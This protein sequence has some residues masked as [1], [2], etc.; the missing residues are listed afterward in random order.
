MEPIFFTEP[1]EFRVWLEQHHD[2]TKELWVGYYKK[3]TGKPSMTWP[4]S[5]DE[6]LCFGWIDG[7]RKGIDDISYKIRFT[8]RKARSIW[9][10]VNIERMKELTALGLVR[11]EGLQ[12][13]AE[14]KEDKS[15]VYAYEQK[16]MAELDAIYEQQVR[17]NGKAWEFFQAQAAGYRKTAVWRIISAKKEETKL[18][19]LAELIEYSE[20]GLPVPSL[21]WKSKKDG[22]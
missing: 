6:A 16:D 8:P 11:P 4:Q 10:A 15:A 14:R 13:F 22:N 20:R 21:T 19:R 17:A 18:K 7:L 9:S 3:G 1:A 2:K 12:A 5:V